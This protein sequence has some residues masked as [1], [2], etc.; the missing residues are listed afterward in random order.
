M[1]ARTV[2]GALCPRLA[3]ALVLA[4]VAVSAGEAGA[5]TCGPNPAS[6]YVRTF[7]DDGVDVPP[8]ARFWVWLPTDP[9]RMKERVAR[10]DVDFS[11]RTCPP[12][13]PLCGTGDAVGRSPR[14]AGAAKHPAIRWPDP[15]PPLRAFLWRWPEGA[16]APTEH[17]LVQTTTRVS[18]ATG[19]WDVPWQIVPVAPLAV[20][21]RYAI[22]IGPSA[23]LSF[24]WAAFHVRG[25]P[26]VTA[27]T[28]KGPLDPTFDDAAAM[29]LGTCGDGGRIVSGIYGLTDASYAEDASVLLLLEQIEPVDPVFPPRPA[30]LAR[31]TR[32]RL[33]FGIE[34]PC[35]PPLLSTP[36]A[37]PFTVRITPVDPANN[38]GK[39]YRL[40]LGADGRAV[41][42]EDPR[43]LA[44]DLPITVAPPPDV[45]WPAA[46]AGPPPRLS[47]YG[48][49]I[50]VFIVVFVAL[51]VVWRRHR[52]RSLDRV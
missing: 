24:P 31:V 43:A 10:G 33:V 16:A 36:V 45:P 17:T 3:A 52:A 22:A 12:G 19:G 40:T 4:T 42:A 46:P 11:P 5:C 13:D 27:P 2:D 6:Q 34:R 48:P 20:G 35:E 25:A 51:R 15:T 37:R 47:R 44:D 41:V 18:T 23:E 26:D 7:P 9:V 32:P 39:P 30:F 29:R 38:R 1:I 28:W 50:L 21:E 8:N 14:T 49:W